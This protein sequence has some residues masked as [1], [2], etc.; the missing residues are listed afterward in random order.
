MADDVFRA[1]Q[2]VAPGVHPAVRVRAELAIGPVSP[3]T[4]PST[5]R[6][7]GKSTDR[8]YL[9]SVVTMQ[10]K[11]IVAVLAMAV[12]G[13]ACSGGGGSTP[14]V[15]AITTTN[16]AD[17]AVDVAPDSVI[18]FVLADPAATLGADEVV[19]RDGSNILPGTLQQQAGS[20]T[21]TWTPEQELPRG[22]VIEV[23]RRATAGGPAGAG[24]SAG[25]GGPVEVLST[26]IVRDSMVEHQFTIAAEEPQ[27][28][29]AWSNG[30][31]AVVTARGNVYEVTAAGL[32]QRFVSIPEGARAFGDGSFVAE[33]EIGPVRFCVRGNL[34]GTTTR[35]PTPFDVAIG[36]CNANGDVVA[37]VSPAVATPKDWGL[38]RWM[39]GESGFSF[40]GSV[41]SA[42]VFDVPSIQLDGTVSLAFTEEDRVRLV[43][44]AVGNLVP[45][46]HELQIAGS[47]AHYDAADDGA[48]L[49]AFMT[50]EAAPSGIEGTSSVRVAR[51]RPGSGLELFPAPVDSRF[52][53]LPPAGA[54]PFFVIGGVKV[55]DY[56]S[57]CVFIRH[58]VSTS[59]Q[60]PGG[61]PLLS[62]T[63]HDLVRIEAD[64]RVSSPVPYKIT[65]GVMPMDRSL[66]H[67]SPARAE[68]WAV[69]DNWLPLQ[70]LWLRSRPSDVVFSVIHKDP[71]RVLTNGRWCFSFDDSGRGLLALAE[72]PSDEPSMRVIVIN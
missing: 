32:E 66:S 55:G 49:L 41:F 59:W 65:F 34:D 56:G 44:F 71:M 60:L 39:Q 12:L 37:Y 27:F 14:Q 20:N 40:A 26:F 24:G 9:R 17:G 63:N 46:Q 19:I 36:D 5:S 31:R 54:Q 69:S 10:H 21:W 43:R 52:F 33:E 50:F 8:G 16:P 61:G 25:A 47:H 18:R 70:T 38:W 2:T 58:G 68:V 7:C 15:A 22:N 51:F 53:G 1:R 72:Q 28:G 11:W 13:S 4:S 35:V 30:R 62:A 23:G 45:E 48:G 6:G 67:V 42:N 3:G 29:L 64:D 57:G